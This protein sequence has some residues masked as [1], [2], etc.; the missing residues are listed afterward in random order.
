MAATYRPTMKSDTLIA[1]PEQIS[2]MVGEPNI[3]EPIC[4]LKHMITC[5]QSHRSESSALNLLYVCLPRNMYAT[6]TATPY[7]IILQDPGVIPI[8]GVH[9]TAG[10]NA[11]TKVT[12]EYHKT[13]Y[14]DVITMNSALVDRFPS[15]IHSDYNTEYTNNRIATSLNHFRRVSSGL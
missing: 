1:F 10:M 11:N 4:A 2:E 12:W 9:D 13:R 14:E 6:Y 8:Y 15:L 5:A 3:R 7:P